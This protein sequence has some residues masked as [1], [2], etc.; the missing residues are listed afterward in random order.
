MGRTLGL[1]V[2][3]PFC[4]VKCFY[5]DFTA[6]S[7][8]KGQMERY[9]DAVSREGD[10]RGEG[11]HPATLYFGGGTPSELSVEA[12]DRLFASLAGRFGP[13]DR[14]RESTFEANPDSLDAGKLDA[15]SSAGISRLSLGLQT[16]D[17]ALLK[18]VGRRH[19]WTDFLGVYRAA[20]ARGFD[21]TVDLMFGLPGQSR[22]QARASVARVLELDPGHASVYGLQVE[23][24]TL[25]GKREVEVDEDLARVMMEDAMEAFEAAGY[26]HYEVSNFARPGRESVHNLNYWVNGPYLGLGCGAAGYLDGERYQNEEKLE[27]YCSRVERGEAPTASAERLEG[28][29]ALG[30][31]MLLR[32]RL[33]DG[34]TLTPDLQDAFRGEIQSLIERG[35]VSL[36]TDGCSRCAAKL[37]LTREGVFL[38]NEVFREFVPPFTSAPKEAFA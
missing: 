17:D 4:A 25:F 10:L 28:K 8:K 12:M 34:M 27:A 19:T 20:A 3:V 35:L 11:L 30:E 37:K 15:L 2:H 14:M 5:C 18:S 26:R 1:Y 13:F 24:R 22:E 29:E 32:L 16:A 31:T 23:D 21:M 38:A 33:I 36:E 9:V 6:F 7:G